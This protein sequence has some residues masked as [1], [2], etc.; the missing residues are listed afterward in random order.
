MKLRLLIP[1]L[2]AA[3]MQLAAQETPVQNTPAQDAPPPEPMHDFRYSVALIDDA[4]LY[5]NLQV[6]IPKVLNQLLLEPSFTF[7]Y[8]RHQHRYLHAVTRER[9]LRGPLRG[10]L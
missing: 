10:R 4:T 6:P 1:F 7:R 3:C 5:S 2:L 8:R 9:S